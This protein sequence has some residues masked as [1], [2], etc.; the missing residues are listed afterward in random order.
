MGTFMA[1]YALLAAKSQHLCLKFQLVVYQHVSALAFLAT[2]YNS[3]GQTNK[4]QKL[5]DKNG[6][7]VL[8]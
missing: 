5:M 1:I 4:L 3:P 7:I 6:K 8:F 2:L